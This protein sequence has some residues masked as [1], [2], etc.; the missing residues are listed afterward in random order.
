MAGFADT[1]ITNGILFYRRRV[2]RV[3]RE[4]FMMRLQAERALTDDEI[5]RFAQAVGYAWASQVRG[6]PLG[7][8]VRDGDCAFVVVADSSTCRRTDLTKALLEFEQE[9]SVLVQQGSPVR[10]TDRAGTGTKGTRLVEGIPNLRF[11]LYYDDVRDTHRPIRY[12]K[13]VSP[14]TTPPAAGTRRREGAVL[15]RHLSRNLDPVSMTS[16]ASG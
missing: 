2:G 1:V 10:K 12:P 6:E 14:T 5:L 13:P 15:S 11:S 7:D 3:A 4:P 8:F 9:M 16:M